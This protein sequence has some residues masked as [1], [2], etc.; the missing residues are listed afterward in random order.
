[1]NRWGK[2]VAAVLAGLVLLGTAPKNA[3]PA[4]VPATIVLD[5]VVLPSDAAPFVDRGVTFVPYRTIAEAL[6]VEVR[7]DG[8]TKRVHAKHTAADGT[9]KEIVLEAGK[10]TAIVDGKAVP[11]PQAPR[12]QNGRVLIPLAFFSRQ[13]GA[14]VRWS[15]ADK[16]VIIRSPVRR[17]HLRAFYAISSFA[18]RTYIPLFDSVAF[19]WSR[20]DGNGE[21]TLEG[22]DFYWPEPA[23]DVT[24]E[25]LLR[26][27]EA[28]GA[29][30]YLMVFAG[31][32]NRELTRLLE[33]PGLRD[34][35][36]ER[37][38]G[39]VE[40]HGFAGVLLDFEGLGW[41][42]EPEKP[43]RLFNEY[44]RLL[45]DRLPDPV[46]LSVAVPPP[47]GAYKGYDY[48]TLASIADDLVLMAYNYGAKPAPEPNG[49]VDEAIR[50]ALKAGVPREKL[51]LGVSMA[52]ETE[53]TL[54]AKLGLAKRYGLK[55]AA[56]WRLGLFG[57][58]GA[59]ALKA[60]A[61]K[62]G[63]AIKAGTAGENFAP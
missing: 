3:S 24:P 51:L 53:E 2:T 6:G 49:K 45:R 60:N 46:A 58:S 62:E 16:T 36:L 43:R 14:E 39:I 28:S 59:E 29:S 21:L 11:M 40:T 10:A 8:R 38:A 44:V 31:D 54:R 63:A 25:S 5:D 35:S 48:K 41:K 9:R 4:A 55:G 23:R 12:L 33:E 42:D 61:V 57:K 30:P 15:N 52:S 27:A 56:F 7:W 22:R 37:L 20:I 50:L 47:N 18:E 13:F 32:G 34:R 17:M 19:G 1:M 26:G